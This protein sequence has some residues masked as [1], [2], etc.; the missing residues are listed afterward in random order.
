[1]TKTPAVA[2]QRGFFLVNDAKQ[3]FANQTRRFHG[4][5][6]GNT[7]SSL[8]LPFLLAWTVIPARHYLLGFPTDA[9]Y[10]GSAS[11]LAK[12]SPLGRQGT[13]TSEQM[14][15]RQARPLKNPRH[16]ATAGV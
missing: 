5:L 9:N 10:S 1:M 16:V 12:A 2:T 8:S 7:V 15:L 4:L 6:E 13:F 11:H 3:P 14:R